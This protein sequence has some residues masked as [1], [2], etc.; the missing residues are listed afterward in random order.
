MNEQDVIDLLNKTSKYTFKKEEDDYSRYDAFCKEHN[1]MLEIKCRRTFYS[2]TMIEKMKYDWNT[3]HAIDNNYRFLY[4]V[5]MP[6]KGK[7]TVYI[8]QPDKLNITWFTKKLPAQ[9]DFGT[10]EWIDKEIAYIPIADA[11]TTRG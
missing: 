2:E 1:V 5:S 10:G 4:A 6:N 11:L 7:E 3:Q 9:T 8:F